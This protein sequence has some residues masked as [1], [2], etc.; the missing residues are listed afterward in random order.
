MG[1]HRLVV[2]HHPRGLARLSTAVCLVLLGSMPLAAAQQAL[3]YPSTEQ[4]RRLQLDVLDCGRDNNAS[5]CDAARQV[6]DPL[7]DHLRLPASCKDLLWTIRERAVVAPSN[8]FNRREQLNRAAAEIMP[9]CR[10]RDVVKPAAKPE[11][12]KGPSLRF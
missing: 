3:T 1:R 9:L 12:Q 11:E 4:F 2:S 5:S 8:S 10:Q 7:L 6:A